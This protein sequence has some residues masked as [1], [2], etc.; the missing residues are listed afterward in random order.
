MS[1]KIIDG[2]ALAQPIKD[3]LKARVSVLQELGWRPHLVSIDIGDNPTVA[4]YIRNQQR[5]AVID[6]GINQIEVELP[7]GTKKTKPVGD[8]DFDS[9]HEVAGWLTPVPGGVG[10]LTVAMLLKNTVQAVEQQKQLYEQ[11]MQAV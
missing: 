3:Q 9:L 2:K 5:A 4:L 6:I 10:P 1:H 11:N 7:D 8:V